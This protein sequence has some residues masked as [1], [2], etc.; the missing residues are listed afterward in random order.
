MKDVT[1]LNRKSDWS[2]VRVCVVGFGVAGFAMTDALLQM[3]AKVTVIDGGTRERHEDKVQLLE[4]LGAEFIFENDEELPAGIDL[5][6]VSPGIKPNAPIIVATRNAGLP[7]WGELELAWRLRD[8]DTAPP[9]IAIT[10]TNGKTTTTR[11]VESIVA[12]QFGDQRIRVAC[13]LDT[14]I[15]EVVM[16]PSDIDIVVVEIGAPHLPYVTSMSPLVSV[17][18]NLAPDHLDYF[19]SFEDYAK[20]KGKIF[21]NTVI[22]AIFNEQDEATLHM[23]EQADVVEGCRAISFTLGIPM[24]SMVGLVDDI[25]VDR[26]FLQERATSALPIIELG[27][28]PSNA[29]HNVQNA[30]A[31]IAVT[32]AIGI[33]PA[34]IKEGLMKWQGSPHRI[35]KVTVINDITY[36]DDSKATNTHAAFTAIRAFESVVWIAGGQAKGQDFDEL[37]LQCSGRLRGVILLGTDQE[38]IAAALQRHAPHIPVHRVH[39]TDVS[40]MDEVVLEA[41]NLAQPGDTVLLAPGCASYD[42]FRDFAHRGDT[43]ANSVRR[44]EQQ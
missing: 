43:F 9:W 21:N 40:A 13:N 14:P 7:L 23:V 12:T 18:L 5:V 1:S 10:G 16:D 42:M 39:N 2:D 36:V 17:C 20:A 11:M 38:V 35:A 15:C 29:P 19:A 33:D 26:A 4:V 8:L 41:T 22:A 24:K 3:D 25:L 44:L 28:L 32:R 30:L 31:A 37:V 34:V 6:V 27:E